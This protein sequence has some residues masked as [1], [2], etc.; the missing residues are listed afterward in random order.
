M[1]AKTEILKAAILFTSKEETRY[2]LKGVFVE[3]VNG[4]ARATA[5]EGHILFSAILCEECEPFEPAIIPTDA[6]KRAVGKHPTIE[7]E[8]GK[9]NWTIG[10]IRAQPIDA[11]FPDWR[12]LLVDKVSGDAAQF[13]PVYIT[14]LAKAGKLLGCK[15]PT[16]A[17][18]GDNV[19]P[20]GFGQDNDAF[21]LIMPVRRPMA[22]DDICALMHDARNGG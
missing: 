12:R 8:P 13:D 9:D 22:Y 17:H 10:D 6:I 14:T 19:A 3:Y 15:Y 4:K 5:T 16:I 20:I 18:N 11:T 1:F 2:Y 21:A 7:I